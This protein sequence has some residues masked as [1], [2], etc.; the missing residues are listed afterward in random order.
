MRYTLTLSFMLLFILAFIGAAQQMS[1]LW[2]LDIQI[3]PQQTSF[4]GHEISSR[5]I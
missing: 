5:A 3:D 4:A 2:A 1:E